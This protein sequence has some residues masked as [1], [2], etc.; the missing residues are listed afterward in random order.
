V[1]TES[2]IARLETAREVVY[3]MLAVN[4]LIGMYL[5]FA[6]GVAEAFGQPA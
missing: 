5:A 3:M 2:Q 6:P 4:I 1:A